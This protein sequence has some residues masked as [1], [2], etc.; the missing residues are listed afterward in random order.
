MPHP[1]ALA[2]LQ[3]PSSAA[4]AAAAGL[5]PSSAAAGLLALSAAG[6]LA[7]AAAASASNNAAHLSSLSS[8]SSPI[9]KES[10]RE[11]NNDKRS[12]SLG[13]QVQDDSQR[14]L[15]VYDNTNLSLLFF[16]F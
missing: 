5:P 4:A 3:P 13:K 12:L 8:A 10:V 16:C 11:V 7:N 2:G 9:S 15:I 14:L 1:A 6:S